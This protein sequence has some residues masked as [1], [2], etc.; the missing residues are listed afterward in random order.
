MEYTFNN[1]KKFNVNGRLVGFISITELAKVL[2]KSPSTLRKLEYRKILP[3]ANFR[4]PEKQGKITDGDRLYTVQLAAEL[5]DVF[6]E[7][8]QG[9]K[10]SEDVKT[11]LHTIFKKEKTALTNATK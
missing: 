9:Q 7:I 4:T 1:V 11:K 6:K 8:R 5:I 3:P 2:G 10:V